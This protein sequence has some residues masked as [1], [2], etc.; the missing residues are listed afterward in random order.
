MNDKRVKRILVALISLAMVVA[1]FPLLG[2]MEVYAAS[3]NGGDEQYYA[4]PGENGESGFVFDEDAMT[5]NELN[6]EIKGQMQANDI[7]EANDL[8]VAAEALDG[9]MLEADSVEESPVISHECGLAIAET[10]TAGEELNAMSEDNNGS[11]ENGSGQGSD[12]E[13]TIDVN[14]DDVG[15]AT[16]KA[17]VWLEGSGQQTR[18]NNANPVYFTELY[19]DDYYEKYLNKQSEIEVTVDTQ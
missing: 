13:C 1:Y 5:K 17:R 12:F 16:V 7:A 9:D 2:D 4:P 10:E 19:V 15:K 11:G 6:A 8:A 3:Q 14:V 18:S